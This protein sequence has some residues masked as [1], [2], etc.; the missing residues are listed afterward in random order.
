[1]IRSQQTIYLEPDE[2][3]T[4]IID[5]LI[6]SEAEDII[7]V[8]PKNAII[9]SSLVNFKLLKREADNLKKNITIVTSDP[10]GSHLAKKVAIPLKDRLEEDDFLIRTTT[11]PKKELRKMSWPERPVTDIIS[12][13]RRKIPQLEREILP[14]LKKEVREDQPK[15]ELPLI[16]LE[17]KVQPEKKRKIILSKLVNKFFLIFIIAGFII[18]SLALYFLLPEARLVITAKKEL[19]LFDISILADKNTNKI[20]L[21]LNKIPAQIIKVQKQQ[22]KD[23]PA[24][25][26][27]QLNEKARGIITV[28]NQ[29]SSSPQ[30]LVEITRFLSTETEKIFR[31]TK[32]IV[33]PGAKIEEGRIVAS[34]IDVEVIADQS[35][36]S[37]NIPPSNFTIP[38]FKGTAKYSGFYAKSKTSMTGGAIGQVKVVLNQDLEKAREVLTKDLEEKI[39]PVLKEQIPN[40]FKLLEGAIKEEPIEAIFSHQSGATVEKFNLNLKMEKIVIVFDPKYLDQLIDR[41]IASSISEKKQPLSDSKKISYNKWQVNFDKGQIS[42]DLRVEEE[43]SFKIDLINL[44][45]NLAGKNESEIK[46]LLSQMPEIQNAKVTFWPFW[47]KRIPTQTSK[48]EISI[49]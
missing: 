36:P 30:T 15:I 1:M 27:R 4:S 14:S 20:D 12:P 22:S 10:I 29:H 44:K 8:I 43:I 13:S 31:T 40:N 49:D 16:S 42:L 21:S 28:Y 48:I 46:K 33:V 23:F 38:G 45:K 5:Q 47:V 32:T 41:N 9:F 3:I 39:S 34:S 11:S 35:G 17:E 19:L 37:Y 18:F 25:G 7:L 26:Q 24:T 2:E 6:R